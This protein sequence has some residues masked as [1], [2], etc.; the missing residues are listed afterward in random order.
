VGKGRGNPR[1]PPADVSREELRQE[2]DRLN[3]AEAAVGGSL[4]QPISHGRDGAAQAPLARYFV[5]HDTSAPW[6][7]DRPFIGIDETRGMLQQI[8]AAFPQLVAE[9]VPKTV[10]LFVLTD[11]LRRLVAEFVAIRNLRQILM[12]LADWGRVEG[13]PLTLTEY[14]RAALQRQ[15]THQLSR[16]MKQLVVFLLDPEIETAIRTSTWHTATG[17]YV[18]LEPAR[19]RKIMDAI[20]E[21]WDALPDG[22]QVP[23]IL[24]IMEI[25]SSV[26]RLVAPSMPLLHVVSYQELSP[27][28]NIQPVGRISLG[29]FQSRAGVSAGGVPL[30][31]DRI[32]PRNPN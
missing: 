1:E 14:V 26:R 22:V 31:A 8:E 3:L 9:S 24:T 32:A 30:W 28:T 23:Q 11:V 29:G 19:L 20:R 2:L 13:D 5:I 27:D 4:D 15:I 17:S 16:G 6:L 25:R 21:A 10:S 7:R 12:A 18:D